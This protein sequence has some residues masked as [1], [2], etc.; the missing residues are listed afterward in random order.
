MKYMEK[1]LDENYMKKLH[2]I[3]NKSLK[4][5]PTKQQLYAHLLPNLGK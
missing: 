2:A 5:H 1:K 3:L 4:Q